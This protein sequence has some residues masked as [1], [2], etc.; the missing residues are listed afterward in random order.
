MNKV[1]VVLDVIF[2]TVIWSG[3]LVVSMYLL[4]L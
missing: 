4:T 2:W 1:L 3:V